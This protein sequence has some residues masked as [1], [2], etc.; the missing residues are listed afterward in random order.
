LRGLD[1]LYAGMRG[2][3]RVVVLLQLFGHV[4]LSRDDVEAV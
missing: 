3:E 2:S 4:T 1:G